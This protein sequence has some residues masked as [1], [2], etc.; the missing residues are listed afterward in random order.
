VSS[1]IKHLALRAIDIAVRPILAPFRLPPAKSSPESSRAIESD[2]AAFNEAAEDYYRQADAAHVANKPF[3]EPETFAKRLIDAGILVDALRLRPGDVVLELGA[4]ACWFSH[5]LNRFGC[6]TIAVDVSPTA[7]AMGRARFEQD[8]QTQWSLQPE[9]LVYD[10]ATLPVADAT[11]DAVV[12]YDTYHHLPNP[13]DVLRELRRVLRDGGAVAM[14]EPGRGHA[15]SAQSLLESGTTGVLERELIIEEIGA[16]ALAMGFTSAR[17][18]VSPRSPILEVEISRL[19]DFMGG[20]RFSQYWHQLCAELDGHH[21]VVLG[22]GAAPATT[23]RPRRLTAEIRF[24]SAAPAVRR[25]EPTEVDLVI[26]NLGDTTWLHVEGRPG[27]TRLGAHLYRQ[28][29]ALTLVDFDWVR[30]PLPHDVRPQQELGMRL[31]LPA[32]DGAGG[33]V[34]LIDLVVEGLTWFAERESQPL[35]IGVRPTTGRMSG[36][37]P[38]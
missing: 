21:Y 38:P 34:I 12:L 35:A 37:S 26:R 33:Y 29:D 5:F 2:A 4:G 36:A 19:R 16:D 3:S 30:A 11:V 25:G 14:S 20:H 28:K 1:R 24:A 6:R 9:F 32:I 10:G 31:T 8:P 17:V 23:A 15:R 13:R 27:W 18:V 7:L 22:T